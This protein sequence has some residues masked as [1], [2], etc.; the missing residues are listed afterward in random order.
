MRPS[1]CRVPG[2]SGTE[3]VGE[4]GWPWGR[5]RLAGLFPAAGPLVGLWGAPMLSPRVRGSPLFVLLPKAGASSDASSSSSSSE[6][7]SYPP[8]TIDGRLPI[9][10]D[11]CLAC[12]TSASDRT[13]RVSDGRRAGRMIC[14][15]VVV[16]IGNWER[17]AGVGVDAPGVDMLGVSVP[18]VD[19]CAPDVS[20]AEFGKP[21][22]TGPA[23]RNDH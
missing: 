3:V 21:S 16:E 22:G 10:M 13:R 20:V 8:V 23:G 12:G 18:G 11:M 2:E 5:W 19:E 9:V 1:P 17:N 4:L 6:L 15:V 14:E 7:L